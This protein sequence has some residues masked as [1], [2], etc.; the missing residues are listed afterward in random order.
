MFIRLG[1]YNA[2]N[3]ILKWEPENPVAIAPNLHLTE[4]VLDEM[5][6]DNTIVPNLL[7]AG[8]KNKF[9]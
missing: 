9:L 1:T 6:T 3:L 4:F 2:S 8:K 7:L 5:W